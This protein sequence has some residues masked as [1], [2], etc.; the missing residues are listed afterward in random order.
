MKEFLIKTE[1]A[2]LV[3]GLSMCHTQWAY[4]VQ[5]A[6]PL[7]S[8]FKNHPK[9]VSCSSCSR[10][11]WSP[12][13][14]RLV[15]PRKDPVNCWIDQLEAAHMEVYLPAFVITD[16]SLISLCFGCLIWK[17]V[18]VRHLPRGMRGL[19]LTV[20]ERGTL[21]LRQCVLSAFRQFHC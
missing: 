2:W 8:I 9:R 12:L 19:R 11:V 1:G 7:L 5:T 18:V 16:K 13:P 20:P 17:V 10:I 21:S 3:V 14:K 15:P 6:F 4:L